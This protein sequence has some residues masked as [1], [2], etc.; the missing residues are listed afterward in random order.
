MNLFAT[1]HPLTSEPF[2]LGKVSGDTIID[3]KA[4]GLRSKPYYF[5]VDLSG[6]TLLR[7]IPTNCHFSSNSSFGTMFS[8]VSGSPTEMPF[9]CTPKTVTQWSCCFQAGEIAAVKSW[10]QER[11]DGNGG[12]HGNEEANYNPIPFLRQAGQRRAQ[13]HRRDEV[14]TH[15]TTAPDQHP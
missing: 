13:N 10:S 12:Q 8:P 6:P 9:V 4:P 1:D 11:H 14:E 7:T 5:P 3:C 15:K 2:R